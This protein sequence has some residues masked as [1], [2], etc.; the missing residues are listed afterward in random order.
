MS[1]TLGCG[2]APAAAA[3]VQRCV[4]QGLRAEL[5]AP[6]RGTLGARVRAARRVP[7]QAVIGPVERASGAVA[8]RLRD[9]RRLGP[10]PAENVVA[11]ISTAAASRSH[12]L[13]D[14]QQS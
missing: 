9:G 4:G 5:V 12:A 6:E 2:T 14:E 3:L 13:W 10:L 8:L 7:Y 11:R 1:P